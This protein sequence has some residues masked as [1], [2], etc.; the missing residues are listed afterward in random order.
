MNPP[1]QLPQHLSELEEM[2][3]TILS[4]PSKSPQAWTFTNNHQWQMIHCRKKTKRIEALTRQIVAQSQEALLTFS[5]TIGEESYAVI[6][7]FD[8]QQFSHTV[9]QPQNQ[10]HKWWIESWSIDHLFS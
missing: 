5:A 1:Q 4:N 2:V 8:G 10:P 9:F 3:I 7:L 6:Y